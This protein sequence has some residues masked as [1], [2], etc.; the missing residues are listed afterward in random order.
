MKTNNMFHKVV[1][2]GCSLLFGL[3]ACDP[4]DEGPS[5]DDYFLNYEIP[6]VEPT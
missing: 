1:I 5:V 2:L 6:D 4:K 3:T